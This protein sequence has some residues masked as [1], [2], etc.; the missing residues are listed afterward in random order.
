MRLRYRSFAYPGLLAMLVSGCPSDTPS[1]VAT[2]IQISPSATVNFPSI[3]ATQQ[4]TARVL[5]QNGDSMP[6]A[7]ITW[8]VTAGAAASVNGSG[9]VTAL[10]NGTAT[11]TATA[12]PATGNATVTVDQVPG[13]IT[14]NGGDT[15]SATVGSALANPVTV[16][17]ADALGNAIAGENVTFAAATG[18]GQVANTMVATNASGI[19]STTWTLGTTAG[20]QSVTAAAGT[21]APVT[22]FATGNAGAAAAI[23]PNTGN[24]QTAAVSTNVSTAPSVRVADAFNNP[25]ANTSVTFVVTSGGGSIVPANGVVTTNA[26]G[27]AALTSWTMGSGAGSNSLSATVTGTGISTTINAAAVVPG[28]PATVAAFVGGAT[29][30]ALQGYPTNLRPAVRVLDS[31]AFPVA[32]VIVNFA[33]SS[34]GGSVTK[35]TDTTDANGV[36]QVGAWTVGAAEGPN[37]LTATAAPL[38]GSPVVFNATSTRSQFN[39]TVVYEGAAPNAQVQAAFDSAV[40]FW[41][42]VIIGDIADWPAQTMTNSPLCGTV[43]NPATDDVVIFARFIPIDGQSNTIARAGPCYIR[44]PTSSFIPHTIVGAMEFDTADLNTFLLSGRFEGV[45]RH[46]MGHVIGVGTLWNLPGYAPWQC[47]QGSA[48]GDVFFNCPV[49]LAAFDSIGGGAYSGN[50]VPV[51][52]QGGQGS[53]NGHW[54]ESVLDEELMT[55]IAEGVGVPTPISIVTI[56]SLQDLSYVVNFGAAEPYVQAFSLRMSSTAARGSMGQY[57]DDVWRGPIVVVDR[58]GRVVRVLTPTP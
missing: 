50:K 11:V 18:N 20:Q 1:P 57:R 38:P 25:K 15:Q 29:Q 14:K 4:L 19:A 24:N 44:G 5:D 7:V 6:G 49:T 35:G 58:D 16:R 3:G 43:N 42:R 46:E 56:G 8:A 48:P 13:Q 22:F 33:A 12:G 52:D 37:T 55:S 45:I 31:N 21:L 32:G 27:I 28:A 47:R 34:G 36:A 39:I 40:A 10:A 17:V 23:A 54:R 30:T 53:A 41:Q 51:E 2:S 9:L 26:Q